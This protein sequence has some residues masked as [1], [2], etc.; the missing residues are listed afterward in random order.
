METMQIRD[1]KASFSAVIAAAESG[2]PTIISRHGHPCAMVVPLEAGQRLY[3]Q[4]T[5]T[6]AAY[7]LSMPEPLVVERDRVPMR[8][9]DL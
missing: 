4:Q 5:L 3:A 8:T 9:I 1:A 6:L 7:L 2:Q